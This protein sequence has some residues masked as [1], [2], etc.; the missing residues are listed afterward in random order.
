M[1]ITGTHSV[2]E[3][4]IACTNQFKKYSARQYDGECYC[5]NG[6]YAKHGSSNR[7]GP[8]NGANVGGYLSCVYEDISFGR[9]SHP[10]NQPSISTSPSTKLSHKTRPPSSSQILSQAPSTKP[11]THKTNITLP[12]SSP[13]IFFASLLPSTDPSSIE[14]NTPSSFPTVFQSTTPSNVPSSYIP[15]SFSPS[16][17]ATIEPTTVSLL[18]LK[19]NIDDIDNDFNKFLLIDNKILQYLS[20]IN[21]YFA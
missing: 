16:N 15:P 12:S 1:R 3:C 4:N 14:S 18:S 8:C 21:L 7:C 11:S 5:G 19:V 17:Q 20:I 6:D 10:S 2:S 9:T 13:T